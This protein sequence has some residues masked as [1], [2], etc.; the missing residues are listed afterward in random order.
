MYLHNQKYLRQHYMDTVHMNL[1]VYILVYF[2]FHYVYFQYLYP[3]NSGVAERSKNDDFL[4]DLY[5]DYV[6]LQFH[7]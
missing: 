4:L 5:V 7:I 2:H 1:L 6:V 3:V